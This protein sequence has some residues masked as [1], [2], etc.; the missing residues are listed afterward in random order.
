MTAISTRPRF[1]LAA[2]STRGLLAK[3]LLLAI[4]AAIAVGRAVPLVAGQEWFWLTVLVLVTVAI[5]V[6]YLQ[7][8]HIPLKYIVPGTIFLVAF[9]VV[10][11]VSTFGVVVHQLR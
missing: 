8:W 9:Q 5:F 4:V 3:I 6:V 11:V 7:P 10:P 1:G 2:G